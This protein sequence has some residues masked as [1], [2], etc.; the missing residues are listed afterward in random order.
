M[1]GSRHNF[2]KFLVDRAIAC[3]RN[4]AKAHKRCAT[5]SGRQT[6]KA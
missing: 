2:L 1:L 4:H 5:V 6:R 3:E